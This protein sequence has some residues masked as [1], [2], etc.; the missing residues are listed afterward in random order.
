MR[1]GELGFFSMGASQALKLHL[2]R[3]QKT[4]S[5]IER[6]RGLLGKPALEEDEALWIAPCNSVHTFGMKHALDIVYVNRRGI[7]KKTVSGLAPRRASLCLGAKS[8][9][10]LKS[11]MIDNNRITIGDRVEW[12][13]N[14]P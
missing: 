11:G 13:E 10:E 7:I 14:N 9:I 1:K 2:R 5:A 3:V 4:E 6:T 8:V 12:T